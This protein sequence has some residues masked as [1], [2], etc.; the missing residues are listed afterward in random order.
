MQ[1]YVNQ[2]SV[3]LAATEFGTLVLLFQ[4][5]NSH[6]NTSDLGCSF[7]A[8]KAL[9]KQVMRVKDR[10]NTPIVLVGNKCDLPP[11]SRAV[12]IYV[13]CRA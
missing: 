11:H 2:N 3:I 8:M 5:I 13:I 1:I 10:D 9:Y 12:S 4:S 7:D 6:S